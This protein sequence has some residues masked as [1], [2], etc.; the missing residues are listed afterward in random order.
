MKISV[1]DQSPIF[2]NTDAN[3]ALIDSIEL[4]KLTDSYGLHRYWVAEHHGSLS[5]AGC[6]PEIFIPKIDEENIGKLLSYPVLPKSF[7]IRVKI[8]VF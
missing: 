1:V 4:A 6:A 7:I 5:F 8:K 3:Q 2:S